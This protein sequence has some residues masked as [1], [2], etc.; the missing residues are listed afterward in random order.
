VKLPHHSTA[1]STTQTTA[2]Q[3]NGTMG[4]KAVPPTALLSVALRAT[5]ASYFDFYKRHILTLVGIELKILKFLH[6]NFEG[7]RDLSRSSFY[8]ARFAS[9]QR[10]IQ[11]HQN[12]I[13]DQHDCG[14][15]RDG[16]H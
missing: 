9:S 3:E 14:C 2:V 12:Q 6:G 15:P 10:S 8:L 5:F 1:G 16:K 7:S 13:R 11:D 4:T